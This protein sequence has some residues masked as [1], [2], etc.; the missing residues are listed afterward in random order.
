MSQLPIRNVRAR[1]AVRLYAL[2]ALGAVLAAC[3]PIPIPGSVSHEIPSATSA[4][5]KPGTSTRADVLLQL[6]DPDIRGDNDRYF[7]YLSSR[8][9]GGV[10]FIAIL[11][12]LPLPVATVT[13]DSCASLGIVFDQT[14]TVIKVRGFQ[15]KTL[16]Q[17]ATIFESNGSRSSVCAAD[18]ELSRAVQDWLAEP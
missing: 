9:H 18:K 12:Y 3:A 1:L 15:G 13:G 5:I 16:P 11:P 10:L 7:I 4:A 17:S 8:T 6:A 2:L 14:G